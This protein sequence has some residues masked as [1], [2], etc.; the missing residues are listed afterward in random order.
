MGRPGSAER[1]PGAGCS[2]PLKVDVNVV[3]SGAFPAL[4]IQFGRPKVSVPRGEGSAVHTQIP[5]Y[6]II[7]LT[8]TPSVSPL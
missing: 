8:L 4:F 2:H 1:F 6:L 3:I 5:I 7:C